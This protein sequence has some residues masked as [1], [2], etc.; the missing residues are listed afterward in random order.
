MQPT[1]KKWGVIL[2]YLKGGVSTQVIWN[3]FALEVYLVSSIYLF[4]LFIQSLIYNRSPYCIH[5]IFN[6]FKASSFV[7]DSSKAAPQFPFLLQ[8]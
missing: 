3:S 1:V 2:H 7:G 4:Y 5:I 8:S 6:F